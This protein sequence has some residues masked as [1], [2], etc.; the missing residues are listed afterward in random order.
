MLNAFSLWSAG[1]WQ[2]AQAWIDFALL[3]LPWPASSL[4]LWLL[5]RHAR[6]QHKGKAPQPP[7]SIAIIV[8]R[9][10]RDAAFI[11]S[12]AECIVW[13]AQAGLQHITVYD[14]QGALP[15]HSMHS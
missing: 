13:M 7:K 10:P 1:L 11:Q 9:A 8:P 12:L 6:Q 5:P 2:Q 4:L 3:L 14:T 15:S